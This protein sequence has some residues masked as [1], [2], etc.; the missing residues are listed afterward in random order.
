M[1]SSARYMLLEAHTDKDGVS[2]PLQSII[3]DQE[4]CESLP[5][6]VDWR[7]IAVDD[8]G[9]YALVVNPAAHPLKGRHRVDC[10]LCLRKIPVDRL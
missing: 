6:A 10:L 3:I 9:K 2:S 5:V 7:V 8:N 1:E 4:T